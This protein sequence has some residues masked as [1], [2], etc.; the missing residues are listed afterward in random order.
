MSTLKPIAY[1]KFFIMITCVW[2]SFGIVCAKLVHLQIKQADLFAR[3]SK[4]NFLHVETVY[5][6]RGNIVDV[7]GK[8]LATNRP[9]HNVYWQGTGNYK[10]S[11]E[12]QKKLH[13]IG[14][15]VTKL[16][17]DKK[18]LIT[19]LNKTERYQK[20]KLIASDIPFEQLSRLEE[21]FPL[22]GNITIETSFA[23]FYPH[24]TCASHL[25]GYLGRLKVDFTGKMGLEHLFEQTLKGKHGTIATTI[26]SVGAKLSETPLQKPQTGSDV[27]TTI[28]LELQKIIETSFAKD[29]TGMCLLMDPENGAI[30]AMTSR[31][32]F[33]PSLFLAP[34]SQSDWQQ[35][36]NEHPF[37]NR[38]FNANYPPGSI[39][40][41]VVTSAALE[42]GVITPDTLWDCKGYITFAGRRYHCHVRHGH[43]KLN[44]SEAL[45]QSCNPFF[46]DIGTK[47]SIDT[48][49]DYA[50]R[51]G[52]GQK[53]NISF[54]EK[55]GLVPTS[56]WK[57]ETFGQRWWPGETLSAAIGQSYL[58]VTPIQVARMIGGIFTGYLVRP[59]ILVDEP[60][61][62][63]PLDVKPETLDF[64]KQSMKKVATQGTGKRLSRVKN[65]ELYIKTSTAQTSGLDKRD[66]GRQYQEHGWLVGQFC[67]KEEKPITLVVLVEHAGSS[68]APTLI[69]RKILVRYKKVV[70][71]RERNILDQKI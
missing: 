42:H 41:L 55:S 43:G 13:N 26:N 70:D 20:K 50:H 19:Q 33:S 21:Q 22:D 49:A 66:K 52:L 59:R 31:P 61:E 34:I 60:I 7:H 58:L 45:E 30:L 2:V 3:K 27:Q 51:F 67:Y 5:S 56:T 23:R 68:R 48:F 28:D 39:F 47:M 29:Q 46:Y 9:T 40:K 14:T 10:L 1:H 8:L 16:S 69:A 18:K 38:A 17:G 65:I 24:D 11:H 25:L 12:Q 57:Q 63:K 44:V 53:T 71:A 15:I 4:K 54:S 37:L 35:L 62:K 32:N 6:P 64:L 36:Q